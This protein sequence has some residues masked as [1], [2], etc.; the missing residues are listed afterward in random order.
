[1]T[2]ALLIGNHE[3]NHLISIGSTWF[4]GRK[5]TIALSTAGLRSL[6]V[7]VTAPGL[8]PCRSATASAVIRR[9]GSRDSA[10]PRRRGALSAAVR[11]AC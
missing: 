8:V 3:L 10:S 5:P 2:L 7:A 11:S 9:L 4:G 1:M 6:Q